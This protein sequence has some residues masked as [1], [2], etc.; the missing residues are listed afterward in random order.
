[1]VEEVLRDHWMTIGNSSKKLLLKL[2]ET[3]FR[4][5]QREL[6]D[7]LLTEFQIVVKC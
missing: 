4:Q 1:M 3:V 7:L 5:E 6:A 2:L